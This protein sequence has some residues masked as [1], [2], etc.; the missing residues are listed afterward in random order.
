MTWRYPYG[1]TA[2]SAF[3][4]TMETIN[5][6][7]ID[8]IFAHWFRVGQIQLP[9]LLL[10]I[11]F[12]GL[13][14]ALLVLMLSRLGHARPVQ[15]CV[16]LSVY[17]HFLLL[18]FAYVSNFLQDPRP[19]GRG[20]GMKVTYID[21][22]E[23]QDLRS[24]EE[25]WEQAQPI[26]S[27]ETAVLHPERPAV[28]VEVPAPTQA[29]SEVETD[30]SDPFSPD[31]SA[32][33][34]PVLETTADIQ[35][36]ALDAPYRDPAEADAV[37]AEADNS[38][39]TVATQTPPEHPIAT[40]ELENTEV[41]S[42]A[43]VKPEVTQGEITVGH[44]DR[45]RVTVASAGTASLAN[46]NTKTVSQKNGVPTL[47]TVPDLYRA[48]QG[49]DRLECVLAQGGSR[50]TEQA[51]QDALE[52]F[53]SAQYPGDGRWSTRAWGGGQET[54]DFSNVHSS[55]MIHADT[56]LTGLALLSFLG[57]GHTQ[58]NSPYRE[59]IEQGLQFLFSQQSASTGS[60]AGSAGPFVA[61][62]CHGIATLA[63]S[64][65]Y[66]LT[67]DKRIRPHLDG[68]IH[69]TLKSQHP[70][71]GGWR[72]KPGDT[73][74]TSQFGWQL[75]SL[76]SARSAGIEI[77]EQAWHGA[78]RFLQQVSL[79][80]HG[81]IACYNPIRKVPS[82]TMTAEALMCR[83]FLQGSANQA[84]IEEAANYVSHHGLGQAP[85]NLYYFY[86]ATL[87]LHQLQDHRWTAWN[88]AI[89]R[90][91]V[92]TQCTEPGKLKGSWNADTRWGR[93]G[94]RVYSTALATLCLES[95]YRYLPFYQSQVK[96]ANR[97]LS[98]PPRR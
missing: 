9:W 40:E 44:Q 63:I 52:W 91:L 72:Y 76:I 77:P 37:I 23:N 59:N 90:K 1:L 93:T 5:I 17:A 97:R 96:T 62:Y 61:M 79:G 27:L 57:A 68:A 32:D 66:I 35:A 19:T 15:K 60:L 26:T 36:A 82:H 54:R 53:A 92:S 4:F 14:I 43:D 48:R 8:L 89:T 12:G 56:A 80:K 78:N 16:I 13:S 88:Q 25:P 75:M 11:G 87:A 7:I 98:N 84:A 10:G 21:S 46:V 33:P 20:S 81:G 65:A 30:L 6:P 18:G 28:A 83:I 51:V 94:G 67:G 86:Y 45:T 34:K 3:A 29:P 95:Y 70:R 55:R 31:V 85:T 38:E 47:E 49:A 64:E 69:F 50:E 24:G 39:P 2:K 74:D 41:H 73:G 42:L 71:T 58:M 22:D